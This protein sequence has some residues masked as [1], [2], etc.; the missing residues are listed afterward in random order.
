MTRLH[1]GYP[2]RQEKKIEDGV[3]NANA[4]IGAIQDWAANE[5]VK[6]RG[7]EKVLPPVMLPRAPWAFPSGGI[8]ATH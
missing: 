2:V 3:S 1:T 6:L 5:L 7:Q 8:P 4:K